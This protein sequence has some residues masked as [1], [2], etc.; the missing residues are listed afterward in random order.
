MLSRAGGASGYVIT[1]LIIE[2]VL[3]R[4]PTL[5][6]AIG[7]CGAG[8]VPFYAEQADSKVMRHR[9]WAGIELDH[10]PSWYVTR[11]FLFGIQD[12]RV[13]VANRDVVGVENILWC[14]IRV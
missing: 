12:D 9:W 11:H 14:A 4:F 1:Q 2:R 10:E 7:E 3:D 8:W 6:F 5:R 13:G